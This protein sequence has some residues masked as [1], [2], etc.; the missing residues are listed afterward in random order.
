ML[1]VA[2]QLLSDS[3]TGLSRIDVAS[4]KLGEKRD[5]HVWHADNAGDNNGKLWLPGAVRALDVPSRLALAADPTLTATWQEREARRCARSVAYFIR[6]YGVVQ[7]NKGPPIPFE[8]WPEQLRALEIIMANEKTVAPKSRQIGITWLG[9]HIGFHYSAF[10]P[11]TPNAKILCLSKHGEDAGKLIIRAR[12]ILELLPPWLRPVETTDSLASRR[13]MSFARGSEIVSLTGSPAAARMETA[14]FVLADEFGF[15]R[16]RQ[17]AKTLTA[18]HGTVEGGGKLLVVSTGNGQTGD[19]EAFAETVQKAQKGEND[20]AMVFLSWRAD[21]RRTDEWRTRK[22]R[23]Y[24][25]LE[26]GKAEY[27]ETVE[28]ALGGDRSVRVY[29]ESHLAASQLIGGAVGDEADRFEPMVASQGIEWGIDWGDFQTFTVYAT[30]LPGGGI[31]IFDELVQRTT[32][33]TQA[34][35]EIVGFLPAGI[36]SPRFTRSSADSNPAGTNK[37]FAAVLA[38][39]AE[40]EPHRFPSKHWR[41]E[42]GRF[43][44]GGGDRRDGVNTVGYLRY[45]LGRAAEFVEGE[46]WEGRLDELD[47][48]LAIHPRCKNL[49]AQMAN[50][51]RD[52]DTGRVRK[53]AL[54][55]NNLAKGDHGPD[56]VVA[57][58]ADRAMRWNATLRQQREDG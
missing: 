41:I 46:G 51:E 2:T 48:I 26:E 7:P 53:P 12:T 34:S 36:P 17:G 1:G 29:P 25:T 28:E 11:E 43:K 8:L 45:L 13:R 19:G 56:A 15:I 47:G 38:R 37:T 20:Y 57:L 54:D 58:G 21:P 49:L 30:A 14:T 22:L 44:Q 39:H 33:P 32:E 3:P 50:L 9:L 5:L 52:P 27:P 18:V 23:S 31:L 16:H 42:F 10:E 6:G 35:E 4:L 24:P 40:A 55:P